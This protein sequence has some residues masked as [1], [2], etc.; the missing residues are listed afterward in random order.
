M[1]NSSGAGFNGVK[2]M[3]ITIDIPREIELIIRENKKEEDGKKISSELMSTGRKLND[4][5]KDFQHDLERFESKMAESGLAS[6]LNEIKNR[7]KREVE[8]ILR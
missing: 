3:S 4:T 7:V 5:L 6:E 1:Q 2:N 8:N